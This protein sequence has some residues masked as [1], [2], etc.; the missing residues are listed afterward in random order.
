MAA[1]YVVGRVDDLPEGTHRVCE[2]GGREIGVFNVKGSYYALPSNCYHQNGPLCRGAVSG[3]I[4]A[5]LETG[6]KPTWVREGEIIICPWHT[7]E[8][9][10]TTGRCLAEPRRRVPTYK[11]TVVNSEIKVSIP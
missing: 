2:V 11:V 7:M 3:T 1:E 9:D 8:F 5:T 4:E 6:W 10:I